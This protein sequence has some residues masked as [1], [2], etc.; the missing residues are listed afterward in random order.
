MTNLPSFRKYNLERCT[1]KANFPVTDG[2]PLV[3]NFSAQVKK[4][5]W[6][7]WRSLLPKQRW[8]KWM[9]MNDIKHLVQACFVNLPC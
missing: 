2:G 9:K 7:T 6:T 5:L 4:L 3:P 1:N 8:L